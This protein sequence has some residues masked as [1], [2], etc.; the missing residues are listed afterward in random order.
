MG[1]LEQQNFLA[2]IFTDESLRLSF[3]ENPSQL[4]AEHGLNETDLT[5]L[6]EII[7][8]DL[9]FFAKSLFHKRLHEVERLLPLTKKALGR[10]FV[11]LFREF[12]QKFQSDQIRKH[13]ADAIEFCRFLQTQTISIKDTA[14]FEKSKLQFFNQEKLFAFCLLRYDVFSLKKK[15]GFAV[16]YRIGKNTHHFIL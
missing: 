3:W 11:D 15:F 5:Q 13:L 16:W 6:K 2:R 8:S 4:A 10:D 9:N 14:R 7:P 1:L 12:T